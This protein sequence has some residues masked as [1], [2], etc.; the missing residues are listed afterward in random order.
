[1]HFLT[2]GIYYLR[3]VRVHESSPQRSLSSRSKY[4]RRSRFSDSV[5]RSARHLRLDPVVDPSPSGEHAFLGSTFTLVVLNSL[6]PSQAYHIAKNTGFIYNQ[7]D[8]NFM[9]IKNLEIKRDN[10]TSI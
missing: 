2:I 6:S 3:I 7:V 9:Y 1:M 10:S 5:R 8:A 4:S